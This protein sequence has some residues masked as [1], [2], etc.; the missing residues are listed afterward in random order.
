[1]LRL[2]DVIMNS[3]NSPYNYHI[4]NFCNNIKNLQIQEN[5][6]FIIFEDIEIKDFVTLLS[7]IDFDDIF[8]KSIQF[9]KLLDIIEIKLKKIDENK[10]LITKIESEIY[11]LIDQL[12]LNINETNITNFIDK[13]ESKVSSKEIIIKDLSQV[14]DKSIN[15]DFV[16]NTII[17][18][19][20]SIYGFISSLQINDKWSNIIKNNDEFI[21][22]LKLLNKSK[23]IKN[24][25]NK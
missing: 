23:Y 20:A 5:I 14:L 25:T 8:F 13:L 9:L 4:L 16:Y 3:I 10:L 22:L 24:N 21:K 2:S 6:D 17:D 19:I 1:M 11:L 12:R 7:T 18:I 15:I